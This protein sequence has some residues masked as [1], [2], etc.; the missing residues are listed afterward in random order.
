MLQKYQSGELMFDKSRKNGGCANMHVDAFVLH[1]QVKCSMGMHG[2]RVYYPHPLTGRNN[3]FS[4]VYNLCSSLNYPKLEYISLFT[5][6]QSTKINNV[7]SIRSTFMLSW[8][9][10]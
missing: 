3:W 8:S 9:N 2:V 5:V 7:N 10:K 6:I 4:L 1:K